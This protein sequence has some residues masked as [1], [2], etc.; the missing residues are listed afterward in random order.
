M[1]ENKPSKIRFGIVGTNQLPGLQV[2]KNF[3]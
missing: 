1:T 2:F 3:L